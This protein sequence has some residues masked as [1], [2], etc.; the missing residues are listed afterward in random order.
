MEKKPA[1]NLTPMEVL[2]MALQR[3]RAAQKFYREQAAAAEP[4]IRELLQGLA[5][6]EARHVAQL[7]D[8]LERYFYPDN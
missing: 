5:E 7:E 6:E 8:A 4:P 2:Q 1:K 3:E